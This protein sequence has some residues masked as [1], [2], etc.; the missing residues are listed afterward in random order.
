MKF[1]PT[2]F[3]PHTV[4]TEC[5]EGITRGGLQTCRLGHANAEE[6][7]ANWDVEIEWGNDAAANEAVSEATANAI[8]GLAAAISCRAEF[9]TLMFVS[10]KRLVKE[11]FTVPELIAMLQSGAVRCVCTGEIDQALRPQV[12]Q[13]VRK[14]FKQTSTGSTIE[15]HFAD[16]KLALF[17]ERDGVVLPDEAAVS[18][19]APTNPRVVSG[20]DLVARAALCKVSAAENGRLKLPLVRTSD[21]RVAGPKTVSREVVESF[22]LEKTLT[23]VTP[24]TPRCT[25]G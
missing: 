25:I 1:Y 18:V 7:A 16:D 20:E 24:P 6:A 5:V 22:C 14:H 15:A 23:H 4:P 17:V 3:P 21:L 10:P 8:E 2:K 13:V 11:T 12:E 19:Q 9:A